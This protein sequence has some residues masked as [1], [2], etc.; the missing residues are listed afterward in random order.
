MPPVEKLWSTYKATADF[1]TFTADEHEIFY[2]PSTG[3][4]RLDD[5]STPG[6]IPL[7][8]TELRFDT[9]HLLSGNEPAGSVSWNAEDETI[10]IVHPNGVVQSVGQ[11][12]YA[13][14]RNKTGSTIPDGTAV[15]FAGAEQNGESRLL[16][17]PMQANN[18]FPSLYVLGVTTEDI[19]DDADGRV[20]VWGKVRN[21]DTTGPGAESWN[22]G[23]I[24]YV[25]P[26]TAGGLTNVRP[27][28]PNNVI[29]IAAVLRVDATE[30]EIFVRPSFE[31]QKNYAEALRSTSQQITPAT[32]AVAVSFSSIPV[33]Q[34]ISLDPA[35][36][37]KIVFAESGF[38]NIAI[39]AQ[40][41][42]TNA[43]AKDVRIWLRTGDVDVAGTTRVTTLT[44]NNEF[45]TFTATHN[46]SLAANANVQIMMAS[47]DN[48]AS[49]SASPATAYAPA[50]N[51]MEVIITQPAL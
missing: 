23:D 36:A 22:V 25:S 6:G 50:S 18:E 10:D 32:T 13:Y 49:I 9:T 51:A 2:E 29:P 14:V 19:A 39:N 24:I 8:F 38:Y 45:K 42:S 16:V 46:L 47:T 27:T 28:A 17:A 3:D 5:G 11:E 33:A 30:G 40:L 15:R 12:T 20:T 1:D 35:D 44:G 43:S 26:T 41:Q 4:L 48:T 31:Q 37:T 21:I 34:Q 7:T